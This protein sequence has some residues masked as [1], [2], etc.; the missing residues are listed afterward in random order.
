ML[1]VRRDDAF[2]LPSCPIDIRGIGKKWFAFAL[3]NDLVA[4]KFLEMLKQ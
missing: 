1:L 2:A 4:D 3:M